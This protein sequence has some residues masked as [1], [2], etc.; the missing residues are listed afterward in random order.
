MSIYFD[1]LTINYL[2]AIAIQENH[3]NSWLYF[4]LTLNFHLGTEEY[5]SPAIL[6]S[7]KQGHNLDPADVYGGRSG[8]LATVVIERQLQSVTNLLLPVDI[9]GQVV[10]GAQGFQ[11]F[12]S[13]RRVGVSREIDL[14]V[15]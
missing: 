6:H 8:S 2:P 14:D 10:A 15:A 12:V 9:P 1:D 11:Q 7:S 4:T 3:S 13:Q 5:D